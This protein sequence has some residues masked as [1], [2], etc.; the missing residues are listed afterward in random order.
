MRHC[1]TL[2]KIQLFC[3]C[4]ILFIRYFWK[5]IKKAIKSNW[6]NSCYINHADDCVQSHCSPGLRIHYKTEPVVTICTFH[7]AASSFP[8]ISS[9]EKHWF[10]TF[11]LKPQ[12]RTRP[13]ACAS[14]WASLAVLLPSLLPSPAWQPQRALLALRLRLRLTDNC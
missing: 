8:N 14:L 3:I 13:T 9:Y 10:L 2:L 7:T 11:V 6:Q 4:C 1:T 5:S 12:L